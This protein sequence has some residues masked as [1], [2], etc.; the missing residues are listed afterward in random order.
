MVE[1]A[2]DHV[3]PGMN[4]HIEIVANGSAVGVIADFGEAV[5]LGFL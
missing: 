3:E 2:P 4:L 1:R 5:S